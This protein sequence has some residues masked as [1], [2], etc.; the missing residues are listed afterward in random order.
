MSETHTP[1]KLYTDTHIAKTVAVQ[2][3]NRG[4]DVVRCEEVGLAEVD[5]YTHLQ[6]AT[7]NGRVLVTRDSDFTRIHAEWQQQGKR[8]G[9]ILYIRGSIQGKG[10]IG[11]IVTRLYDYYLL[12]EGEAGSVE[13]D[14]AN[15]VIYVKGGAT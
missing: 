3:R 4:V 12:V 1:L 9:G 14:F 7:E 8:H 2:L 13:T 10:S 15:R 6:Y 11:I 5:D